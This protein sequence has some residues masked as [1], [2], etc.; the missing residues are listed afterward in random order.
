MPGRMCAT[1]CTDSVRICM[2]ASILLSP[3]NEIFSLRRAEPLVVVVAFQENKSYLQL[4]II[5]L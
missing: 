3:T 5:E 2:R 1:S 4:M